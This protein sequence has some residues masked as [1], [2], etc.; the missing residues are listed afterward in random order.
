MLEVDQVDL[1]AV[2]V[3]E[4]FV[5]APRL[6]VDLVDHADLGPYFVSVATDQ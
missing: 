2:E 6:Q 1:V 5:V 4:A 3:E